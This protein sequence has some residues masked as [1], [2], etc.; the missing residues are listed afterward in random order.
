MSQIVWIEECIEFRFKYNHILN[1]IAS[2][3]I[4]VKKEASITVMGKEEYLIPLLRITFPNLTIYSFKEVNKGF[5]YTIIQSYI[6]SDLI[7]TFLYDSILDLDLINYNAGYAHIHIKNPDAEYS[8]VRDFYNW[9]TMERDT[10]GN[11]TITKFKQTI[12]DGYF[13]KNS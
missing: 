11:I 3:I 6:N 1:Y 12:E 10:D 13:S 2:K 9:S 8:I 7:V 5:D 4:D